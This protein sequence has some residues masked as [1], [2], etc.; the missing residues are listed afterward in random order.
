MLALYGYATSDVGY[1]VDFVRCY[2]FLAKKNNG[3]SLAVIQCVLVFDQYIKIHRYPVI[4]YVL[5]FTMTIAS[6]MAMQVVSISDRREQRFK[7]M[8][9]QLDK[10][11]HMPT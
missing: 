10:P 11:T 5:V 6:K 8:Y 7:S 3:S 1:N 2:S 4:L 9:I